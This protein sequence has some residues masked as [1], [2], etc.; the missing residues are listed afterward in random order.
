MNKSIRSLD[1]SSTKI[2]DANGTTRVITVFG[3]AG[4]KFS[5][6]IKN[7]SG[8][9]ILEDYLENVAIPESGSYV[10][11]QNF[12]AYE[13]NDFSR[14][15]N[16]EVY[17]INIT[18][19][20]FTELD[21]DM[22]SSYE[23]KQ[24][25]DPTI[26]LT[27]NAIID[28]NDW[29]ITVST[30]GADATLKGK[31]MRL[32]DTIQNNFTTAS[33]A[34]YTKRF[35]EIIYDITVTPSSGVLYVSRAANIKTDLKKSTN[36]K[37]YVVQKKMGDR[38]MLL[39]IPPDDTSHYSTPVKEGMTFSGSYTC[40]KLFDSNVVDKNDRGESDK[41]KVFDTRNLIVGMSITGDNIS[42]NAS[43]LSIDNATD[44]TISAKQKLSISDQLTFT[45]KVSGKID[46]VNNEGSVITD[47]DSFIA[48]NT[49]LIFSNDITSIHGAIKTTGSGSD[50][51]TLNSIYQVRSFGKED[52]TFTQLINNFITAVPNAYSQN[53]TTTKD[54][55]VTIDL[56]AFDK[57]LDT[58]TPI[59]ET[60]D[61]PSHGE[62]SPRISGWGAGVG[63]TV[64]TPNTGYTGTD[65]FYFYTHS[66]G[67]TSART[68]I[69]VTIT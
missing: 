5:L 51:I 26:T 50:T 57:D 59:N 45:Q 46:S 35:G 19:G 55:A 16:T 11:T 17:E 43:I 69:Y 25:P 58:K 34:T 21:S 32:A 4:A 52:V 39:S 10:I 2:L 47:S 31:A 66:G 14:I 68:P 67:Q 3:E 44:I 41:I 42:G 48:S 37:R 24:H 64:Y 20:S 56:L 63:T 49:E 13:S 1:I 40:V 28:T 62:I 30:S 61:D 23:I 22:V 33:S 65:K 9:N 8:V 12:P 60:Q 6:T 7:G 53:V 54:T 38:E 15:D 18:H 29:G 36:I 27:S